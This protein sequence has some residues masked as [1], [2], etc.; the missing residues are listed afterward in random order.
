MREMKNSGIEWI[1]DIPSDW[2]KNKTIRLFSVIGS[3]TTPKSDDENNF[4]GDIN[5]IQS[6]D[7]NGG[8]LSFCKNQISD[9]V[10][11]KYSALKVYKAPFIVIAMY[12]A[13]IGNLSI[14]NIDAC[15][16]QAC[17]VLSETENDFNYLFYAIK[18]AKN[19]LIRKAVGGGQP[20]ISQDTIKQLWLPQPSLEQQKK[21]ADFLDE[22]CAEIDTVIEKTK[23]TIEEYKKL[24]QSVITQAV[25]KGIRPNRPMKD[26]GI[27]WIGEIPADW[28]VSRVG[29]HFNIIL[30][31]MLCPNQISDEYTLEPYYCA[32]NVHF[33]GVSKTDL[34]TMWFSPTEKEQYRVRIGDLLVV[35]GGAGAG[36]CAVVD[37]VKQ[38][39]YIQNSIMIV[40]NESNDNRFLR[41]YIESLVKRGYIDVVCNK[42]TI[43]HFTKDK[44]STMPYPVLD[45]AEQL[46]IA[47]YLEKNV[48][49]STSLSQRKQVSYPNSKATKNH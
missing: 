40:R 43:P 14:S 49:K 1:G 5:W 13:S 48:L 35:E 3:G 30:G 27:E 16:N 46:C 33:D 22:K 37:V 12:G 23:A 31:K 19:Y 47:N 20:N 36:G 11:S 4:S 24:K 39:I 26:S 29:L 18:T 25:T 44:L 45:P 21:I 8:F 42:A 41:Y 15:V 6:G 7:I 34:K 32:A 9:E 28:K 38:E 17:C 10:L 2:S